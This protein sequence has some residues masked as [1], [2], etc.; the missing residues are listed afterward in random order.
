MG[1]SNAVN[2]ANSA[3]THA[4]RAKSAADDQ[5]IEELAKAVEYLARAVAE[6]GRQQD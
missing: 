2:Y 6:V 4:R 3:A 5:A 1:N